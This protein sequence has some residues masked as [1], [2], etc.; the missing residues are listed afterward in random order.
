M[1][2]TEQEK[3]NP[4]QYP[5][6]YN[7]IY[8]FRAVNQGN[9]Y[10]GILKIGKASIKC[11]N[12]PRVKE[13]ITKQEMNDAAEKRIRDY[14]NTSGFTY[15]LLHT[16][17]AITNE[18]K[19]FSDHD[20]HHVL[21]HSN[22]HHI[23]FENSN[24]KEWFRVNLEVAKQAIQ[25]V[26]EGKNCLPNCAY[27]KNSQKELILYK[28]QQEAVSTALHAFRSKD[29]KCLW[30]C[31]MRFGKTVTALHLIEDSLSFPNLCFKKILII[32]NRPGVVTQWYEDYNT[33]F[34]KKIN[35]TFYSWHDPNSKEGI[36]EPLI[37][38]QTNQGNVI[39]FASAQNLKGAK[40]V[41]G[42]IEKLDNVLN[43]NWDLIIIDE[44]HEGWETK[45]GDN[46]Y[47]ILFDK[48][49]EPCRLYL[50]GTPF[51][52]I[53]DFDNKHIFNYS[54]I[55]EQQAKLRWKENFLKSKNPF[56]SDDNPYEL[57]PQMMLYTLNLDEITNFQFHNDKNEVFFNFSEFFKTYKNSNKFIHEDAVKS[58]LNKL[59]S[60][61]NSIN[62]PFNPQFQN[63]F[64][65]TLW[66]VPGVNEAKALVQLLKNDETFNAFNIV[67]VTGNNVSSDEAYEMVKSA[68]GND[69]SQTRTIT[70]TC[71]RLTVGTTIRPWTAILYLTG[72]GV[73][74]KIR[75]LQTIFRVQSACP[76]FGDQVKDTCYVF[77]FAP[78][79]ALRIITSECIEEAG[80]NA[81]NEQIKD[82]LVEWAKLLPVISLEK[83]KM[84]RIGANRLFELIESVQIDNIYASGFTDSSLFDL[85]KIDNNTNDK[86]AKYADLLSSQKPKNDVINHVGISTKNG[87]EKTNA[88]IPSNNPSSIDK[89]KAWRE[90]LKN[91]CTRLPLLIYAIAKPELKNN[92]NL[93]DFI[94]QVSD[95]L[96]NEF[97][98]YQ[99]S[100][101]EFKQDFIPFINQQ[102]FNLVV[103]KL[104]SE[105]EATNQLPI[106]KITQRIAK[107]A[108]II[109]TFRNPNGETI[110]TPWQIV[111]M[112]LANCF[113][114]NSFY[115]EKGK[116]IFEDFD[117]DSDQLNV[118]DFTKYF[119]IPEITNNIYQLSN[120][121]L[122][123]NSKE[124][125]YLLYLAYS[126]F[127]KA[128][129]NQPNQQD[130]DLWKSIIE[131]NIY[132]ICKNKM[133]QLLTIKTLAWPNK[134]IHIN[135]YV[136]SDDIAITINKKLKDKLI[137]IIKNP[138]TWLKNE[139]N[140]MK[141]DAIV[142][143][144]PYGS[145]TKNKGIYTYFFKLALDLD[146]NYISLIMPERWMTCN[147]KLNW[148][149]E[150]AV[151]NK[152]HFK[153][154]YQDA[155]PSDIFPTTEIKGGI[156][157]FLW[158]KSCNSKSIQ[159]IDITKNTDGSFS[160]QS[161]D[162]P[163]SEVF[164]E[165]IITNQYKL[166]II[167]KVK[168][169]PDYESIKDWVR[170]TNP[171]KI[172]TNYY[173]KN[174]DYSLTEVPDAYP[175]IAQKVKGKNTNDF[176][177]I[178]A[179]NIN[180]SINSK[181]CNR[182]YIYIR[183]TKKSILRMIYLIAEKSCVQK[184]LAKVNLV[185]QSVHQL[186]H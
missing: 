113:G 78:E 34:A 160:T 4:Y 22:I 50:S 127:V 25:C 29:K 133:A 98:P 28:E 182:I 26:I 76:E 138:K 69:P 162:Y 148:V 82:K 101:Q 99:V 109:S 85:S 146:P 68:I 8:I 157:Y 152:E 23:Q 144:P 108:S 83:A 139:D 140:E 59:H 122:D 105:I 121:F 177:W 169:H 171:Y 94:N 161:L 124:G 48:N 142:G 70:I 130:E 84:Q 163:K 112:Q 18:N 19:A 154:F 176:Q 47:K 52:I 151:N 12:H 53:Y 117:Q 61:D 165:V 88:K 10:D 41:G 159:I 62:Y 106:E 132:A 64:R 14:T 80:Q 102:K 158:A 57:C 33:F 118:N 6:H 126:L 145:G 1:N 90:I 5:L 45:K 116:L 15:Q 66:L 134:N 20:V 183:L 38:Y 39:A 56:K 49:P 77:D 155:K 24:A 110:F 103:D 32:T 173:E 63:Y 87:K 17:L 125:L 36:G 141:F 44:A 2:N 9:K 54:Y 156:F 43:T 60:S 75:Y 100:R 164:Q 150:L 135:T 149:R 67:D 97:F 40:R 153:L 168:N 95:E 107:L 73:T 16:Q 55:D 131:N 74:S 81:T 137:R 180:N 31:K 104:L 51:N 79:R 114:G 91:V 129:Q 42:N 86:I 65:H 186:H 35:Y 175:C 46:V 143:N 123:V 179:N 37:N 27:E 30:N 115:D 13:E 170:G 111:N 181:K 21:E 58:F 92:L 71:D 120:K 93:S 172:P 167:K 166:S 147:D 128:K 3:I 7:V 178:L 96:W 174:I 11:K 119:T 185:N 89:R 136:P 184:Q 72:T